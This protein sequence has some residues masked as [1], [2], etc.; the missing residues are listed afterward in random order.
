MDWEDLF[1]T[2]VQHFGSHS[3][4]KL[5]HGERL[6][7]TRGSSDRLV[8]CGGWLCSAVNEPCSEGRLTSF[9]EPLKTSANL[10]PIRSAQ[11]FPVVAQKMTKQSIATRS[12]RSTNTRPIVTGDVEME[13]SWTMTLCR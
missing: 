2:G 13:L 5:S 9:E 1:L 12:A 6:L 7:E 11:V 10:R 4:L 3:S 8:P